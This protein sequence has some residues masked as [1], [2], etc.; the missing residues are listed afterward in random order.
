MQ[1]LE[2]GV[3]DAVLALHLADQQQGIRSDGDVLAAVVAGVAQ[4]RQQAAVLGHV[5]GGDANRAVELIDHAARA[6]DNPYA[7]ACRAG[8]ASGSAVNPED[9]YASGGTPGLVLGAGGGP[10]K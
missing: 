3:L 2:A 6:V 4:R 8:I 9:H 1:D 7:V 10:V 5:V